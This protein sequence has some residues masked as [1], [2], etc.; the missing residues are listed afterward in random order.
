MKTSIYWNC[1]TEKCLNFTKWGIFLHCCTCVILG[2]RLFELWISNARCLTIKLDF[3][4]PY[5]A[6]SWISAA[7]DPNWANLVSHWDWG[8]FKCSHTC[9]MRGSKLNKLHFPPWRPV[10]LKCT[11]FLVMWGSKLSQCSLSPLGAMLLQTEERLLSRGDLIW[12]NVVKWSD[13]DLPSLH[14]QLAV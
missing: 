6:F 9:I 10:L 13:S 12:V 1:K 3:L 14:G 8:S 2:H 4:P 7:R 5:M 11:R